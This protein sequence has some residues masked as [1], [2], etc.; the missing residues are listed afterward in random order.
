[1]LYSLTLHGLHDLECVVCVCV[2]LCILLCV[3][4]CVFWCVCVRACKH[5]CVCLCSCMQACVCVYVCVCMRLYLSICWFLFVQPTF[6]REWG[7][8]GSWVIVPVGVM[9][10]CI[11]AN[12]SGE[13]FV[14]YYVH[15]D[16]NLITVGLCCRYF[17]FCVL[18]WWYVSRQFFLFQDPLSVL[19]D[20]LMLISSHL[21]C[22]LQPKDSTRKKLRWADV[23]SSCS[24]DLSRAARQVICY[25][26]QACLMLTCLWRGTG[27]DQDSMSW[28][29]GG[30]RWLWRGGGGY[31]TSHCTVTTHHQNDFYITM[32]GDESHFNVS[33]IVR[34]KEVS[35]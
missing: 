4:V 25:I 29:V 7:V 28:G 12:Q 2:C 30:G 34:G 35:K 13:T 31:C 14:S 10:M 20:I 24:P 21:T 27:W 9:G 8:S 3:C 26:R 1:M 19:L 6:R 15:S 17:C 18:R 33:L 32:S 5:V 23:L 11:T 16:I 22:L